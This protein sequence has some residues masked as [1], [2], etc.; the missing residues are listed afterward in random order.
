MHYG[1]KQKGKYPC[2]DL[3]WEER[4]RNK[5]VNDLL[6]LSKIAVFYKQYT[7]KREGKNINHF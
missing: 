4:E 7:G 1:V 2:P 3:H 6:S 5:A